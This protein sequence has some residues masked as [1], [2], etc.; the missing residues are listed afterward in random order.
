M[1]PN[2][3]AKEE[4]RSSDPLTLHYPTKEHPT[5]P[6]QPVE[7]C[8]LG[9]PEPYTLGSLDREQGAWARIIPGKRKSMFKRGEDSP[10]VLHGEHSTVLGSESLGRTWG[11]GRGQSAFW[12]EVGRVELYGRL[13]LFMTYCA[14]SGS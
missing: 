12:W 13:S 5:A 11:R 2:S 10:L 8:Q 3:T 7:M 9:E 4:G 14:E 1:D 6:G